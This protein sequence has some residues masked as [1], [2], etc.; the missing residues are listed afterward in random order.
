M[1]AASQ[2]TTFLFS[3]IEGSTRLWESQPERMAAALTR[4]DEI[5]RRVIATHR[6]TLVKTTGDGVH[7]VFGDPLNALLAAVDL[8]LQCRSPYDPSP[9]SFIP[10]RGT[11]L[12]HRERLLG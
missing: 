2:V 9:S 3:D 7:A 6:G 5:A 1:H 12:R 10:T 11:Q 4:H 8:E